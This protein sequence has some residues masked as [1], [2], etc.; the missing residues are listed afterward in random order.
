[1]P[2]GVDEVEHLGVGAVAVRLDAVFG[3]GFGRAAAA[4][5]QGGEETTARSDLLG[6]SSVHV[7]ILSYSERPVVTASVTGRRHSSAG[8][9]SRRSAGWSWR[10]APSRS[11]H[12]VTG[13]FFSRG[14]LY[15]VAGG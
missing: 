13:E 4:L 11:A 10:S 2:H 12:C 5:V 3:E 15:G 7:P 1:G 14:V 9:R 8:R 6:L